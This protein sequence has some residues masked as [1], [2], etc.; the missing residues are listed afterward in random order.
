MKNVITIPVDVKLLTKRHSLRT[1]VATRLCQLAAWLATAQVEITVGDTE[2]MV[3]PRHF[4]DVHFRGI[5]VDGRK[6]VY[7]PVGNICSW[8]VGD[9]KNSWC[10]W[11]KLYFNEIGK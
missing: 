8:S 3:K 1:K 2:T 7:C 5:T 4:D 9:H 6:F 10:H 11:C